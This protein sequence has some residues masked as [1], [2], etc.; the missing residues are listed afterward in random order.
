M[1]EGMTGLR[2]SS[3]FS[4]HGASLSQQHINDSTDRRERD[5]IPGIQ[6]SARFSARPSSAQANDDS[7][8][9]DL[10]TLALEIFNRHDLGRYTVQRPTHQPP[11][12]HTSHHTPVSARS[13][14]IVMYFAF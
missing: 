5:E 12:H 11:L 6:R 4:D 1:F 7:D 14:F 2:D 8:D 13:G 9:V 10:A 3:S